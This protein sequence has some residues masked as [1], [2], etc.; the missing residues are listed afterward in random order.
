[1]DKIIF[2][3]CRSDSTCDSSSVT[4]KTANMWKASYGTGAFRQEHGKGRGDLKFE[5]S[6]LRAQNVVRY[7][8]HRMKKLN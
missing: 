6:V 1:M 2:L 7:V 3:S 4:D 5:V 8:V